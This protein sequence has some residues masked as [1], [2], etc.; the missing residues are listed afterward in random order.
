MKKD[1]LLVL[2]KLNQQHFLRGSWTLCIL[3]LAQNVHIT[4]ETLPAVGLMTHR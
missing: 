3:K 2:L 1:E 4:A